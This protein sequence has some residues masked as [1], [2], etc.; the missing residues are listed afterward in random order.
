MSIEIFFE[1]H[2]ADSLFAE[3][4]SWPKTRNERSPIRFM[5]DILI[6]EGQQGLKVA[7]PPF[8]D[9]YASGNQREIERIRGQYLNNASAIYL[10]VSLRAIE[11]ILANGHFDHDEFNA[12]LKLAYTGTY[13]E[14]LAIDGKDLDILNKDQMRAITQAATADKTFADFFKQDFQVLPQSMQRFLSEEGLTRTIR[15]LV[16]PKYEERAKLL[17]SSNG[18]KPR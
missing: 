6:N 3:S 17:I 13:L 4:V 10:G 1:Q 14:P 7:S 12:W 9:A 18:Q 8:R 5:S 2:P 16:L 15:N 11:G